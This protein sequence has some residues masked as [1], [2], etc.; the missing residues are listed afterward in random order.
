MTFSTAK[1]DY[2]KPSPKICE[3]RWKKV[4]KK[5]EKGYAGPPS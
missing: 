1:P 2:K 3:A 5:S 4:K